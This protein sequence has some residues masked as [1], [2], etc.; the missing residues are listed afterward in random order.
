VK[1]CKNRAKS[2]KGT[3]MGY[4]NNRK[5]PEYTQEQLDLAVEL[6]AQGKPFKV[7]IDEALLNSEIDFWTYR[8]AYHDFANIFERARQEGLEHLADGLMTAHED[9]I[10][11]QRARLKSDNAKWL[12]SKRKP[13]IYG[14]KVDIHV[15]QTIDIGTAL[16]EAKKRALPMSHVETTELKDVGPSLAVGRDAGKKSVG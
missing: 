14:D 11:V 13:E 1:S 2:Q 8:Q 16:A 4:I 9:H 6:A 10:D 12:L 5:P 7:I 15:S 3:I